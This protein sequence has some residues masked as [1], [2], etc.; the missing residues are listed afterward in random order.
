M[1]GAL[2]R[3][4]VEFFE[5]GF[6]HEEFSGLGFSVFCIF[7]R[8]SGI[9]VGGLDAAAAVAHVKDMHVVGFRSS[10]HFI[11]K[12]MCQ[13]FPSVLRNVSV[14]IG[15]ESVSPNQAGAMSG[16]LI[17]GGESIDGCIVVR[18]DADG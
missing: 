6:G 16:C 13:H 2:R 8:G 11:D 1:F 12:S 5:H 4:S 14:A 7:L 17:V 3:L 10:R 15:G 9:E 18:C